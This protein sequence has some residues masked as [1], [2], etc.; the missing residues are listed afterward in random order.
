MKK[1]AV[2]IA[3]PSRYINSTVAQLE[4]YSS[5]YDFDLFIFLW[6]GDS[7]N[8]VREQEEEFKLDMKRS[9]C[10]VKFITYAQPYSQ[11][12]YDSI[13]K[14]R[15]ENGQS[16]ASS[17]IGMF[18]SMRILIAQLEITTQEYDLVLRIRTDCVLISKDFFQRT[19]LKHGTLNVSKNYLIPHAWVSDHIISGSKSDM[20]KLWK[21]SSNEELYKSY[22]KN[23]M[24]PEKLLAYKVKKE[25]LEVNELWVRYRDYHI[26]YFPI[27]S[28]EPRAYNVIISNKSVA[29]FY[30]NANGIYNESDF[31]VENMISKMKNNQDYYAKPKVLKAIIKMKKILLK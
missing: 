15:T 7:G 22:M 5:E 8:K 6:S 31:E 20:I 25:G 30:E 1:C 27:K 29:Y 10:E 11:S 19:I 18:N 14:T 9:Y 3:G 12:E 4:K 28:T 17:I 21:W 26:V 2:L 16:P 23:D 13:F 24:N